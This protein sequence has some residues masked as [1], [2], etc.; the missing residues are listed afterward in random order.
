MAARTTRPNRKLN[1]Q[2]AMCRRSPRSDW[3]RRYPPRVEPGQVA[4]VPVTFIED[5]GGRAVVRLPSGTKTT[6]QYDAL[7]EQPG[8]AHFVRA[9][10]GPGGDVYCLRCDWSAPFEEWQDGARSLASHDEAHR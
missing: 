5:R 4:L 7:A 1:H 8:L 10:S 6:L 9:R 3:T 2:R